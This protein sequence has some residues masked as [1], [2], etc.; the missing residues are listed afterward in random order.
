MEKRT[1]RKQTI[2]EFLKK[3]KKVTLNSFKSNK[4]KFVTKD[5]N[6]HLYENNKVENKSG[7]GL[8]WETISYQLIDAHLLN[9]IATCSFNILIQMAT[10]GGK[11]F[12]YLDNDTFLEFV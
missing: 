2:N 10:T 8:Q 5:I 3:C 1:F 11:K 7:N 9:F 12:H 6:I 4:R